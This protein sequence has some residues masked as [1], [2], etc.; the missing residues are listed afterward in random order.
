MRYN[1]DLIT[2]REKIYN[3]ELCK[4]DG[5]LRFSTFVY[6]RTLVKRYICDI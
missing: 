5:I 1:H 6:A 2:D 4:L 3:N